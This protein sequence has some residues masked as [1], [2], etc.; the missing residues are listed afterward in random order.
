MAHSSGKSSLILS[1]LRLVDLNEG[2]IVIDGVDISTIS[3]QEIRERLIAIPQDLFTLPGSIR[4]NADTLGTA[5]D[6]EIIS[7]L[8]KL[9]IWEILER[10]GGLDSVLPGNTLSQGEQQLF[11][12]ARALLRKDQ[13][14]VL[15]LDEATSSVDSETD[16][17]MQNVIKEEFCHHTIISV[18][19]RVGPYVLLYWG[20]QLAD[21]SS[22]LTL[23]E[24]QT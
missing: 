12:L 8:K 18:A 19:H 17:V 7:T 20:F 1:L 4:S 23:F 21:M 2:T 6:E 14:R 22:S 11:G 9:S 13:S 24:I 10:R 16:S 15:I 3:R 5:S